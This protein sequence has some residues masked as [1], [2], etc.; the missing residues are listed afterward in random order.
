MVFVSPDRAAALPARVRPPRP[1]RA[2]RRR[3]PRPWPSGC[4]D[5]YRLLDRELGSLLERTDDDDLVMLHVRPR[6]P[7]VHPRALDEQ[8]ARARR[9]PALR[10][11]LGARQPARLGAACARSPASPTTAFGLHGRVAVPTTA[12]RLGA[13]VAPT[14]ASSRRVRASRSTSSDGSRNGTV[15]RADYERVRD[16]V[17]AALL[18]F[19]DPETGAAPDRRRPPQGGRP[20]RALPRPRARPPAPAGPALQ[21]DARAQPSWRRPT[22]CRATTGP[23]GIYVM[24]G[25]E[26]RRRRRARDL[27]RRLRRADRSA[28]VG[29]SPTPSGAAAQAV[30]AVGAF[31]KEEERLVEERLRDLGYLE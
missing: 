20:V 11:W 12:D 23:E 19:T 22:G 5:V 7:A 24:A 31:T 3:P 14:R 26:H 27:A 2:T 17:A 28:S 25:P 30:E 6:A 9:V 15:S 1:S 29:S 13:H 16:E 18:E 4:A 8:G 21:P 10:T